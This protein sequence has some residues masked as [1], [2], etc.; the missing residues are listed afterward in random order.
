MLAPVATAPALPKV[1]P[2][3]GDPLPGGQ[4]PGGLAA[5]AHR[6]LNCPRGVLAGAV[7]GSARSSSW[8]DA[9]ACPALYR[10][11]AGCRVTYR[12]QSR[13]HP[14]F[15]SCPVADAYGAPV[16]RDQGPDR[17]AGHGK[18]DAGLERN[19]RLLVG[20]VV[21]LSVPGVR[22][23]AWGCKRSKVPPRAPRSTPTSM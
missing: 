22:S 1:R 14:G 19:R 12:E 20:L 21:D 11:V 23:V 16:L 4:E 7:L 6:D 9:G 17:P 13:E 3:L 10:S 5:V 15:R 18:A 8:A 2:V